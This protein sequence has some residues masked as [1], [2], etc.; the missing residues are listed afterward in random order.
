MFVV[1]GML[2]Y[3]P[4]FSRSEALFT[5]PHQSQFAIHFI[6]HITDVI[7]RVKKPRSN[8]VII[9][10]SMLVAAKVMPRSIS[11][12]KIVPSI[13]VN[14]TV[15]FEQIQWFVFVQPVFNRITA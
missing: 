4:Y 14:T 3:I 5:S 13:P 11:D 7:R 2:H 6:R 1:K 10:P 15:R 9:A 12:V 8:P